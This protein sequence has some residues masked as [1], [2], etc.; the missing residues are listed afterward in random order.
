M[1]QNELPVLNACVD[2]L[3][4]KLIM[5]QDELR[6]REA[7]CGKAHDIRKMNRLRVEIASVER[8]LARAENLQEAALCG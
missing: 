8:R 5:L 6:A 3:M 1:T 7:S 2:K 4:T